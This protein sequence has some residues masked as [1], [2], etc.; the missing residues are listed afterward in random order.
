MAS[1]HFIDWVER[2]AQA[3]RSRL[4]LRPLAVLDPFELARNME[5]DIILPSQIPGLDA[6]CLKQ[7]LRIDSDAWSAGSL[8]L[9]SGDVKI[10]L[11]PNH[12][13]T[14]RRAT[15]MEELTHVFLNHKPTQLIV[16]DG[17][18]AFR[19]FKKTH[20]TEAYWVG[21]AALVPKAALERAKRNHSDR[22]VVAS[23]FRVSTDLV[24]FRENVTG[25]R[26]RFY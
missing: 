18:P 14:R 12:P 21:A 17:G 9:P 13:D 20:E 3:L 5:A 11:N 1:K 15:L 26:L 2:Q 19:S 25:L 22:R 10:V 24:T 7:L 4:S 6:A 8:R 23:Y 16:V